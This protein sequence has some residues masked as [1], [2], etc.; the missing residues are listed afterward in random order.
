MNEQ[1]NNNIGIRDN[2]NRVK[3]VVCNEDKSDSQTYDN[4]DDWEADVNSNLDK[5]IYDP[6][7][8]RNVDTNLIDLLVEKLKSLI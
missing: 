6:S 5:N 1:D 7:Q 8:C 4:K 2:N 3:E